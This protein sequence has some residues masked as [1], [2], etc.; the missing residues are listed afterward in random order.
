MISVKVFGGATIIDGVI[1][2]AQD[3]VVVELDNRDRKEDSFW[4]EKKS[5]LDYDRTTYLSRPRRSRRGKRP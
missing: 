5:C 4:E 2:F 3:P 1:T